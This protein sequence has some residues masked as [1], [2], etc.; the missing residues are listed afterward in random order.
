VGMPR[1]WRFHGISLNPYKD[2]GAFSPRVSE[3]RKGANP[4]PHS[5]AEAIE[6]ARE[7]VARERKLPRARIKI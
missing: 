6:I 4:H 2:G 1:W 3:I 5:L 7:Q